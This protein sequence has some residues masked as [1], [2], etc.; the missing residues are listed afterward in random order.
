MSCTDLLLPSP[1][2]ERVLGELRA[3]IEKAGRLRRE[4]QATILQGSSGE[5]AA[6]TSNV[7]LDV[8]DAHLGFLRA[9]LA[10]MTS[11]TLPQAGGAVPAKFDRLAVRHD[12]QRRPDRPLNHEVPAVALT[13]ISTD[14]GALRQSEFVTRGRRPRGRPSLG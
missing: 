12:W 4:H 2:R 7:V 8:I 3:L 10:Y 5:Q 13:S 14:L 9:S 1:Y 6:S 11:C